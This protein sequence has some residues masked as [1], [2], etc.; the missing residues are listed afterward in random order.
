ML[1]LFVI[2]S[3]YRFYVRDG[4]FDTCIKCYLFVFKETLFATMRSVSTSMDS[5]HTHIPPV[6]P[7]DATAAIIQKSSTPTLLHDSSFR[8]NAHRPYRCFLYQSSSD[9]QPYCARH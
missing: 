1:F 7:N 5:R 3:A 8:E 6:K 4:S 2:D 9:P